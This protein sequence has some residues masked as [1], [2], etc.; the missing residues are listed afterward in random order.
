MADGLRERL[1]A[2]LLTALKAKDR[3]RSSTLRLVVSA[4]QNEEISL[5]KTSLAE[6]E[7]LRVVKQEAKRRRQAAEAYEKGG[8]PERAEAERAELEILSAYLP[9]APV[10]QQP[11]SKTS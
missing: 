9:E 7:V 1:R 6:E 5:K 11:S 8:R 3:V 2:D 10:D 4:L